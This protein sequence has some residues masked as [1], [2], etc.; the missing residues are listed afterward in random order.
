MIQ[1]ILHAYVLFFGSSLF[2]LVHLV[3]VAFFPS[4]S[5]ISRRCNPF[6]SSHLLCMIWE[7]VVCFFATFYKTKSVWNQQ[8]FTIKSNF[9]GN[10]LHSYRWFSLVNVWMHFMQNHS[11]IETI[12]SLV[13]FH[14]HSSLIYIISGKLGMFLLFCESD[15]RLNLNQEK[16]SFIIIIFFEVDEKRILMFVL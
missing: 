12:I 4:R 11:L 2:F 6:S 9:N 1:N 13:S 14:F 7:L 8:H 5:Y 16:T 15:K 3:D 10:L